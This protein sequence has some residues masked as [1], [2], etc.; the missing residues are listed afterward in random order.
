MRLGV[1]MTEV[2][3]GESNDVDGEDSVDWVWLSV[4]CVEGDVC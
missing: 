2:R 3:M 1:S 4:Q